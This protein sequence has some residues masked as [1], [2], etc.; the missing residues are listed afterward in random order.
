MNTSGSGKTRLVL[1][2]LYHHWGIYFTPTT[3]A[4]GNPYGSSDLHDALMF[5]DTSARLLPPIE[6]HASEDWLDDLSLN[7]ERMAKEIIPLVLARLMIL[8]EFLS[9]SRASGLSDEDAR[10]KWL[11]MQ[12]RPKDCIGIDLFQYVSADVR[13]WSHSEMETLRQSL[14]EKH[15]D[16]LAFVAVDEAQML[17]K[18][19]YPFFAS[20]DY[21]HYQPLLREILVYIV[22]TLPSARLIVSGTKVDAF[23][24]T[25]ALEYS[26]IKVVRPFC[27][28][29]GFDSLDRVTAY[30]RHYLGT[31]FDAA[32]C[33]LAHRWFHGR[34]VMTP[35]RA[36]P[37]D[38]TADTG[39][40]LRWCNTHSFMAHK[41]F[42]PF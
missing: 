18:L 16:K 17:G 10:V 27:D 13:A 12:L 4:F 29:G 35:I 34:S 28:L 24:V 14:L 33:V 30:M 23:A 9:C 20:T 42:S 31:S 38:R 3:D 32:H 5:F 15:P 19:N 11:W 1:E 41:T 6:P 21:Q 39:F 37:A 2:T 36:A 40:S 8:D 22:I 26:S 25:D 7:Q